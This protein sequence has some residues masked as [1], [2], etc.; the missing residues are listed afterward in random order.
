MFL[1]TIVSAPQVKSIESGVSY[2]AYYFNPFNGTE[3]NLG[4]V[5]P[6]SG[7]WQAPDVPSTALDWIL[8]LVK[9]DE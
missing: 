3:H 2:E 8:V 7:T 5:V 1:S 6:T 4:T 9:A